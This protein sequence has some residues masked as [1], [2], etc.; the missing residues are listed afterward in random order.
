NGAGQAGAPALLRRRVSSR[1]PLAGRAGCAPSA[2]PPTRPM[3]APVSAPMNAR[4]PVPASRRRFL[5]QGLGA[6]AAAPLLALPRH[7]WAAPQRALAFD[8]LHT[9]E[10]IDLVYARGTDYLPDALGRLDHFLRDHYSG[11]V[12]HIDPGLHDLLHALRR[13]LATERP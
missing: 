8:H 11:D 9:R 6:V 2:L 10:Q 4:T 7:V 1:R 5:R 13:V 12:G 3:N